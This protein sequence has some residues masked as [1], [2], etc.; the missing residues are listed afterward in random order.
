MITNNLLQRRL[1]QLG[2]N[3]FLKIFLPLA[4]M[5]IL[6]TVSVFAVE[7]GRNLEAVYSNERD[8]AFL[9]TQVISADFESAVSDLMIL[10]ENQN[11]QAFLETGEFQYYFSLAQEFLSFANQRELYDQI[12]FIDETGMEIVRV[13]FNN[14]EPT[15]VPTDQHQFKGDRYYFQDT[16]QLEAGQVFVSPLDLNIEHGEIEQPIKPMIRFGTVVFDADGQKRGVIVLNYFGAILS[17][18]LEQISPTISGQIMLLNADGYWLKGPIQ[19]DEWGFMYPDRVEKTFAQAY[20][21]AWQQI[22]GAETGQF[23]NTDGL[24]TFVTVHPF[25]EA[26]KSSTGSGEAFEPSSEMIEGSEITWKIVLHVPLGTLKA[27]TRGLVIGL[28]LLDAVLIFV[29]AVGAWIVTRSGEKLE[30]TE[31]ELDLHKNHLEE[32]LEERTVELRQLKDSNEGIIQN[33]QEG[34]LVMDPEGII[35]FINPAS[36][37]LLGYL[38]EEIVG[39]HWK[40]LVSPDQHEIV[41]GA[42]DRRARGESGH[43]ELTLTRKNGERIPVLVGSGN[44]VE[45]GQIVS[46]I[47]VFTDISTSKRADDALNER[48][49]ELRCL[50][51]IAEIFGRPALSL[52]ERCLEAASMLPPGWQFPEITG[53]RIVVEEKVFKTK[54]FKET[55]WIQKADIRINNEKVGTVDVCYLKEKP[56]E[57][58]GPFLK[59]E[60]E[61]INNIARQLGGYIKRKHAEDDLI[62]N[63]QRLKTLAQKLVVAQEEERKRVA[64]ELH[65]EA[66]QAL[67]AL[68]IKLSG[69]GTKFTEAGI[70]TEEDINSLNRSI[71]QT[72]EQLR[73]IAQGLRPPAIDTLG[74]TTALE[75]FCENLAINAGINIKYEGES[76]GDVSE[77]IKIS[78]Y[79]IVQEALSNVI[80][81]ADAKEVEVTLQWVD[82]NIQLTTMDDGKG[83]DPT[84]LDDS[85]TGLG[86]VGMRERM[87]LING[88]FEISASEKKGTKILVICPRGVQ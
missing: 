23:Q 39:Q 81:H 80:R 84:I 53:G 58:E 76:I 7:T 42:E 50:Y 32:L 3:R 49:K 2:Q 6:T 11:L 75:S 70:D 73:L 5:I 19:E 34:I 61:L 41:D 88:S 63:Q 43:Y 60:R 10:S 17:Q 27:K 48:V 30:K 52:D 1:S 47:A 8:H 69:L 12:R 33:M 59:E 14:G 51:N 64:R 54:N 68:K 85:P 55:K 56:D 65:D 82:S 25:L 9:L 79:R 72:H 15:I 40:V 86:I 44:R 46:S 16:F 22:S 45:E 36:S 29:V 87:E 66:G 35:T 71:D 4:F 78:L 37:L 74:L 28:V 24:F 20:P 13:N 57:Y 77:I 18:S 62:A 67:T 83:F 21:D 31:I 38:P 26:W